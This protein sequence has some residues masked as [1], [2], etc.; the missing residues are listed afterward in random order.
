MTRNITEIYGKYEK[1]RVLEHFYLLNRL[2]RYGLTRKLEKLCCELEVG[3]GL[4][5]ISFRLNKQF[6]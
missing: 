4:R 3:E 2:N 5:H 1:G 6:L